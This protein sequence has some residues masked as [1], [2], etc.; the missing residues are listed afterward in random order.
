MPVGRGILSPLRL[1]FRHSGVRALWS[2]PPHRVKREGLQCAPG[3]TI[4]SA[5][6]L[7]TD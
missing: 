5:A 6:D 3:T 7:R 2:R 4:N 1:P